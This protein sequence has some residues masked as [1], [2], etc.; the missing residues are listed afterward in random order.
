MSVSSTSSGTINLAGISGYDFS[1]IISSLVQAYK[2]PENQMITQQ[3]NLQTKKN[4]W[5]DVNT[6]LSSLDNTLTALKDLPTWSATQATSSNTS[7]LGVTTGVNAA[8]GQYN[9]KILSTAQAQTV[10]SNLQTVSSATAA[11]SLSAG[12][13]TISVGGNSQTIK[14]S[15]GDSLQTIADSI[16][17]AKAGVSAAVY[18]VTNNG[19]NSYQLAITDSKTGLA[20]VPGF[21]DTSGNV[22]QTLGVIDNS[23]K[24]VTIVQS[25]SDASISVNGVTNI[26]SASNTVTGAIPGVTLNLNGSDKGASTIS[27][28][29]TADSSAAQKAVQGFVDQYN[30]T[31]SF[32][33]TELSYNSTTKTSGDLYG[34]QALQGIQVRLRSITG[35][36]LNNP[37][38]SFND[39]SAIGITTSSANYGED[40]TLSF[41]TTKFASAMAADPQS[42]AN[43]LGASVGTNVELSTGAS[44]PAQGLANIMDSYLQPMIMFGGSIAQN[45][46]SYD[47]QLTDIKNQIAA[48]DEKA[49]AYQKTLNAQYSALETALAGINSTGSWLTAQINAMTGSSTSSS[50]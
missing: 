5:L 45:Q 43:L 28:N 48:F 12:S 34:D 23:Q 41:D 35:G 36:T 33:K 40:P 16:N 32:I 14:V 50:K 44:S 9:I 31:M 13:F 37:T 11:T 7:L 24:P 25:A 39:L 47:S 29:V 10:V 20:N 21:A 2:I 8:Q 22:L 17:N 46:T 42:V 18:Q 1:G 6:R 19:V 3:T 38:G 15:A 27:V 49:T 26:T 4:A 30:S